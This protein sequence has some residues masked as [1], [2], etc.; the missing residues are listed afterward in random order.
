[1]YKRQ[2]VVTDYGVPLMVGGKTITLP[3]LMYQEVIG[4]LNFDTGIAVG[5]VLLIPA[6]IAFVVDMLNADKGKM[7]F[8]STGFRC[9]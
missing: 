2:L 8:V 5:F 3:V 7:S 1:M 6:V 9:V 4:L